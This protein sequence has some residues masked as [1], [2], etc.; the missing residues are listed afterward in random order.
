MAGWKLTGV[1]RQTGSGKTY[2]MMGTQ[3][4][5]GLIPRAVA[6]IFE[7]IDGKPDTMFVVQLMYETLE[8]SLTVAGLWN[9]TWTS[10]WIC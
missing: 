6:R 7:L 8:V 9:C 4:D 1:C 10:S 3:R 2:T 5:V